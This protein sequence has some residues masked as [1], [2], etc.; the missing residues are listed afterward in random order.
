[1][2]M[3]INSAVMNSNK[4]A[5][6]SMKNNVHPFMVE[7]LTEIPDEATFAQF[8]A[9]VLAR[10]GIH[11]P[12]QKRAMLGHRLLKRLRETNSKDFQQYYDLITNRRNARELEYALELIT[13]NETFF[14]REEKHFEFLKELIKAKRTSESYRVWSAACSTGEEPYSIAMTLAEHCAANW[15]ILASDVNKRVMSFAKKG[16]YLDERTSLLPLEYRRR[17]CRKG[18]DEFAGHLRVCP[19]LRQRIEFKMFN[20]LE[21]M[22]VL[23][24]FDLVF[25]RNV[26]IYFNEDT[27]KSI[28]SRVSNIIKPGGY[29]FIGHSES[30]FGMADDFD[31]VKPSIYRRKVEA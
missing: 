12:I 25:L 11:L 18:R 23:G 4:K 19:E 27:K 13:T 31:L 10:L 30:L 9:L 3:T 8:Q 1:M 21:P 17:Y 24:S 22:S 7:H 28:V 2:T 26:M 29:L 6:Q 16:I 15:S 20:L 5:Q 14:F